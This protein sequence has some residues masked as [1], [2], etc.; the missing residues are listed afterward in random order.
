MMK[1]FENYFIKQNR[2]NK[3]LWSNCF[4]K[5]SNFQIFKLLTFTLLL[6]TYYS[7]TAQRFTATA[8]GKE[9][10]LNYTFDI[11]YTVE[12]G[13]LQ[14]FNP[15][16]FDGFDVYGPSTSQNYSIVNG[17]TSKSISYTYTL[18][19]KKQ[20]DFVIPAAT[21]IVN[22]NQMRSDSIYISVVDS[23]P[24]YS[25]IATVDTAIIP[26]N[27]FFKIKYEIQSRN[28]YELYDLFEELDST[29][30]P[31]L[32]NFFVLDDYGNS[33]QKIEN[34]LFSLT[35]EYKL[36]AKE[37]GHYA[38]PQIEIIV[39][40]FKV[41]SNSLL[42]KIGK[43]DYNFTINKQQQIDS[44]D[45]FHQDEPKVKINTE[46]NILDY[47]KDKIFI[48]AKVSKKSIGIGDSVVVSYKLYYRLECLDMYIIQVPVFDSISTV[49]YSINNDIYE[50]VETINHK[51]FFVKEFYRTTLKPK[52]ESIISIKP[53]ELLNVILFNNSIYDKVVNSTKYT[54]DYII[55]SN[56]IS[57]QVKKDVK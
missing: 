53:I 57:I 13:D 49:D 54:Y 39:D 11:T 32:D 38:I 29:I 15:P 6:T 44:N 46:K 34:G 28:A 19:P 50:S 22:G 41:K 24:N 17:R 43:A 55:K 31:K 45:I 23:I 37:M 56:P 10:P 40:S 35:K 20:G 3:N 48:K 16:K 14:K 25:F 1:K 5:F 2:I 12:N 36:K 9:I 42:I 30:L 21:A 33:I 51:K 26:Y 7:S 52:N 8:Q 4:D 47:L 18:Q 27:H